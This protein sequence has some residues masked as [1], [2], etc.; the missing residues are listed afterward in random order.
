MKLHL[1]IIFTLVLSYSL[2]G[3]KQPSQ[4]TPDTKVPQKLSE[5]EIKK[6]ENRLRKQLKEQDKA[7][8][9]QTNIKSTLNVFALFTI[10]PQEFAGRVFWLKNIP[11]S[12]EKMA[13]N[14]IT[15][16]NVVFFTPEWRR[17]ET[18]FIYNG[19]NFSVEEQIKEKLYERSQLRTTEKPAFKTNIEIAVSNFQNS[20]G[21]MVYLVKVTCIELLAKASQNI[22]TVGKCTQ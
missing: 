12:V 21:L 3:Q 9:L 11:V 16:L 1:L 18:T 6:L 19:I 10:F 8:G 2:F 15:S 5:E 13:G 20:K 7:S 22:E 17:F 14:S 4:N